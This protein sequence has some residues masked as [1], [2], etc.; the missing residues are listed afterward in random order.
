MESPIFKIVHILFQ[1]EKYHDSATYKQSG[2][3]SLITDFTY[4][5]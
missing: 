4:S 5:M 3:N 2:P 1:I